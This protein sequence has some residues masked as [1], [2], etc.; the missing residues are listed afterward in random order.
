MKN[1]ISVLICDDNLAIR[2]AL[3]RAMKFKKGIEVLAE[4]E[5]FEELERSLDDYKADVILMDVNLAGISGVDG[6]GALRAVGVETPVIIMS[7]DRRNEQPALDAGASAFFYKGSTD[8]NEL[9][10][11]IKHAVGSAKH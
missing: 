1:D 11:N 6:I 2:T 8:M 9:V 3:S 4:L 10:E 7:A 5:S